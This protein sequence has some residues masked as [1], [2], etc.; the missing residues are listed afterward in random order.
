MP[1]FVGFQ[2]TFCDY[3]I[4]ANQGQNCDKIIFDLHVAYSKRLNLILG[5]VETHYN[6]ITLLKGDNTSRYLCK[7]M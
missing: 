5:D 2:E 7:K 4:K 1:E 3:K 6:V